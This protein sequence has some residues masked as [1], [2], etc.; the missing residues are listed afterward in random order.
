MEV[1]YADWKKK[2]EKYRETQRRKRKIPHNP[3]VL[4]YDNILVDT[5]PVF[6][7][8]LIQQ[9]FT[10][11]FDT[12]IYIFL[13]FYIIGI[14]LENSFFHVSSFCLFVLFLGHAAC[15]PTRDR[16]GH[17]TRNL[18]NE[19]EKQFCLQQHTDKRKKIVKSII[20]IL[21]AKYCD[22]YLLKV[23]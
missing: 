2:K 5:L 18:I 19:G 20:K 3:S 4:R 9:I 1:K 6:F 10:E 16:S 8:L 14:D 21:F 11:F 23:L 13:S 22:K 12:Y 17:F 7:S 15:G